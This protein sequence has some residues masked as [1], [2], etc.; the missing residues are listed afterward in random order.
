MLAL[1]HL[2]VE[3]AAD[4]DDDDLLQYIPA[5]FPH[6]GS[7]TIHR[8]RH[9]VVRSGEEDAPIVSAALLRLER[10]SGRADVSLPGA[11][12][13][14]ARASQEAPPSQDLHGLGFAREDNVDGQSS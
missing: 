6:L 9:I 12:R 8:N 13:R 10:V 5:A 2:E 7:L 1:E 3:Y 11:H 4:G 14:V